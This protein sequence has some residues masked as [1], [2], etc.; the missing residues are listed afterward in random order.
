MH[1]ARWLPFV[2]GFIISSI[3]QYQ[4]I[5]VANNNVSKLLFLKR[6]NTMGSRSDPGDMIAP[7]VRSLAG[8]EGDERHKKFT[9]CR[10]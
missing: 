10:N 7:C 6:N 3:L 9:F 5:Y 1:I 8:G 2:F 4:Q